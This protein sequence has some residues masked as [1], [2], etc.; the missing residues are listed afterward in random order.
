MGALPSIADPHRAGSSGGRAALPRGRARQLL[1]SALSGRPYRIKD[2]TRLRY[3]LYRAEA[4]TDILRTV[5]KLIPH[6]P[7][8]ADAMFNYLAVFGPRKPIA[9]LCRDLV[10]RSPYPYIRGEAW[11]VLAAYLQK[12]RFLA[13][14]AVRALLL[15]AVAVAKQ[16]RPENFTETLGACHFLAFAETRGLGRYS[17]FIKYQ[18]PLLQALVAEALPDEAF[19][20]GGAAAAYLKSTAFEPGIAVCGRIHALGVDP[21]T[22]GINEDQLP[23]QVRNT[24]CALGT[25]SSAGGP[26]DAIAE[27]LS[28]RYGLRAANSWHSLLG[29]EYLHALGLL[30]LAEA[31]FNAGMSYWLSNQN[32]F[33]HAIF[34]ALQRHLATIAHPA[35][36]TTK[37]ANGNLVDFGV[38]LDASGPFSRNCPM[39]ADVFRAMNARRNHL[40]N[41]HPY[42]KKTEKRTKHLS[43]A[44][45]SAFARALQSAL[46][47]FASLM[48]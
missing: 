44:E 21:A 15:L 28:K 34:L 29:G 6:H 2:K 35:A 45:R 20:R 31:A 27:V 3:V 16:K 46:P 11:L 22:L 26:V 38:M 14:S 23:S 40:P 33:H 39:V 7:E 5:L 43:V 9:R 32:S 47:V 13:R 8:H 18:P 37:G 24:L 1:T 10:V 41:S 19:V 36:C 12:P 25:I 4:D 48:P 17:R 30:K 42:E